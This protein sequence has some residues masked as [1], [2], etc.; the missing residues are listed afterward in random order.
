MFLLPSFR[1]KNISVDT[2][3]SGKPLYHSNPAHPARMAYDMYT[4][5][6]HYIGTYSAYITYICI[7]FLYNTISNHINILYAR[8]F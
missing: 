8:V 1:D 7:R 4:L 2:S 5:S 3:R 6:D